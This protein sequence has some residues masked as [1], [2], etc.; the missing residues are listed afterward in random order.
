MEVGQIFSNTFSNVSKNHDP[1]PL[2]V[3]KHNR[4]KY[5]SHTKWVSYQLAIIRHQTDMTLKSD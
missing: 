4:V 3:Q 1:S 2:Q 5:D